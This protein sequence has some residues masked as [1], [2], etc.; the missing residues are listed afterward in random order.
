MENLSP[1]TSYIYWFDRYISQ[2]LEKR[3]QTFPLGNTSAQFA[4]YFGGSFLYN[5]PNFQP[6]AGFTYLRNLLESRS[7]PSFI[8]FLGDFVFVED[9][10]PKGSSL[11]DFFCK[12]IL[13][14]YLIVMSNIP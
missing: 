6:A 7:Y 11:G 10:W 2:D 14:F 3:F 9:P 5:V 13:A 4:F 8:S 12:L 1:N